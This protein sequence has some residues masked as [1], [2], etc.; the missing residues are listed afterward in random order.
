MPFGE[1]ISLTNKT[2]KNFAI[3]VIKSVLSENDRSKHDHKIDLICE[4]ASVSLPTSPSCSWP[5]KHV[6]QRFSYYK[7]EEESTVLCVNLTG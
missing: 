1:A 4:A 5:I 6:P 7:S 2:K 3:I